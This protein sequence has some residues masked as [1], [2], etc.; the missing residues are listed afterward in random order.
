MAQLLQL[1]ELFNLLTDFCLPY[2]VVL[3]TYSSTTIAQGEGIM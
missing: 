3:K 2:L 1:I